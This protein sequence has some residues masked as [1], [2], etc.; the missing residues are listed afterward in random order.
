MSREVVQDFLNVTGIAGV[1]LINR[2]IRPCFVRLD[3]RL[4]SSQQIA[5]S[6]GLLQVVG[7]TSEE[8]DAFEF[9]F[10]EG[11][12]FLYK[13]ANGLILLV[14]TDHRLDAEA[15]EQH[16]RQLQADFAQDTYQVLATFKQ[17]AGTVNSNSRTLTRTLGNVPKPPPPP[18]PPRPAEAD[19]TVQQAHTSG[20]QTQRCGGRHERTERLRYAIPGQN[21][22]SQLLAGEPSR[23]GGA[24]KV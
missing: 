6:Q 3:D 10:A 22:C 4:D 8:F 13:L 5:L 19:G 23:F 17:I 21:G 16:L 1:A 2:R 14:L 18:P 12:V 9:W 7:D 24:A 15:Y 11:R 20:T